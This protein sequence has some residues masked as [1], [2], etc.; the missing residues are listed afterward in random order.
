MTGLTFRTFRK[1][2]LTLAVLAIGVVGYTQIARR[3]PSGAPPAMAAFAEQA[4][5]ILVDKPA[6]SLTLL[7]DNTPIRDYQISLGANPTGHKTREGDE[8]TPEGLYTI[9]WRNPNSMA[10]LSLHISYPN[11]ADRAAAEA[12]DQSP[13]GDIMIH[14]IL[15]GW[16][17]LGPLQ[18]RWDW[19]NGCI[20][21]T[22]EDMREIWSLV[23]DGTPIEI[24]G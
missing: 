14:G 13:G 22:N 7:R 3:L 18:H 2:I 17:F 11:E 15:N 24:K 19:T 21:V 9:D 6:R 16:G 1:P 4:D 8:R 23:P 20:A 12:A 5:R 10:H